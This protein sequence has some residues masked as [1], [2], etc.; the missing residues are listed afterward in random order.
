M[1]ALTVSACNWLSLARNARAYQTIQ[2]GETANLAV[3][4]SLIY[5]TSAEAGLVIVDSHSGRTLDTIPPAPLSESVD[6]IAISGDL[7]FVL[8]A[9]A[10]GHLST[11]TLADPLRPRLVASPREVPV[12]PFSGVSAS[13]G[14]CIVSGGTSSLTAWRYDTAGALSGPIATGDFGRGQPDVLI[15]PG[16]ALALISTHYWGP[17]FGLDVVRLDSTGRRLVL[18]AKLDLDGAGFTEGGAKPANFPIEAAA[19]GHDT[20]LIAYARG[21]AVIST[22]D[23]AHPRLLARIDVGGP[24]VNVDTRGATALVAVSG[25]HPSLVVLD[26]SSADAR[27]IKRIALAAGTLPVGVA[28]TQ[29]RA[30]VAARDRGVMVFGL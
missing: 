1:L 18:L 8:D 21:V 19:L 3:H 4:D 25:S 13:D 15:A 16:G 11:W 26:F 9:R 22:A 6:D 17:Y 10:P 12:G 20:V 2:R 28:L 24:A 29:A 23:P 30:A 7:L 5:A 14:L 27:V